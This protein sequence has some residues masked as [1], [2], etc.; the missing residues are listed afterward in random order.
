MLN[1]S[2][3]V[4]LFVCFSA[5][6]T[7]L[8]TI[9]AFVLRTRSDIA[10]AILAFCACLTITVLAG[11]LHS[12]LEVSAGGP[13]IET[14]TVLEYL[15]SMLG[16]YGIMFTLPILAHRLFHHF[17]DSSSPSSCGARLELAWLNGPRKRVSES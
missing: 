15:E 12:F 17:P 10:K 6:L 1:D 3:L 4:Y 16:F 14:R 13:P 9:V 8:G 5:G 2:V 7:C 11:L